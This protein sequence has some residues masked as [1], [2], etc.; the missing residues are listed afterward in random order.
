MGGQSA[1]P[2]CSITLREHVEVR[3]EVVSGGPEV[4]D[5]APAAG[6]KLA[7]GTRE[8]GAEAGV[9]EHVDDLALCVEPEVP[10]VPAPLELLEGGHD[11]ALVVPPGQELQ[12]VLEG[13]VGHADDEMAAGSQDAVALAQRVHGVDSEV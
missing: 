13:D 3:A 10:H 9:L 12:P 11:V 1:K 5:E 2:A 8:R 6:R 7:G 4:A